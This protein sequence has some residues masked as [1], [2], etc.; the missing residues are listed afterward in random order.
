MNDE[1]YQQAVS[2]R[3]AA[4]DFAV[5]F[6]ETNKSGSSLAVSDIELLRL[7]VRLENYL[8]TGRT[9]L[10]EPRTFNF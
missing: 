8:T 5:R 3:H 7:S 10:D 9:R 4:L 2:I 1:E 6:I